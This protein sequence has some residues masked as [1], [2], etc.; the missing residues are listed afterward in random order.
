MPS[1]HSRDP[2]LLAPRIAKPFATRLPRLRQVVHLTLFVPKCSN[3][4]TPLRKIIVRASPAPRV[5]PPTS[6]HFV[7]RLLAF[8]CP[9]PASQNVIFTTISGFFC[10]PRLRIVHLTV[11]S[12]LTSVHDDPPH[13]SSLR[14]HEVTTNPAPPGR[15]LPSVSGA[16]RSRSALDRGSSGLPPL[17][18]PFFLLHLPSP[19]TESH[20][21]APW[22]AIQ[23]LR[24]N[25]PLALLLAFR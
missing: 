7:L 1:W 21:S 17:A 15:F 16:R 19:G 24:F 25:P 8:G 4:F 14:T 9:P 20:A 3:L 2:S 11:S 22:G 23:V 5:E 13:A 10:L 6:P 18:S 12:P